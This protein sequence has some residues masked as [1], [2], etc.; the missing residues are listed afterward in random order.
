[1]YNTIK[2]H[3]QNEPKETEKNMVRTISI[4]ECNEVFEKLVINKIGYETGQSF[5]DSHHEFVEL[6]GRLSE[7]LEYENR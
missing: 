2:Y 6:E 7:E 5:Y 3:I 4:N 1:M